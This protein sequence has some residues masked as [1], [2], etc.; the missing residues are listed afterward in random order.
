MDHAVSLKLI[1]S[2]QYIKSYDEHQNT[3]NLDI[4]QDDN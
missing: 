3:H 2:S 1:I 4:V